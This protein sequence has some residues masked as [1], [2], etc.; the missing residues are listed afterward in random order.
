MKAQA[1]R[2]DTSNATVPVIARA[3][4]C[5]VLVKITETKNNIFLHNGTYQE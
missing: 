4:R 1:I 5:A 3:D 2:R